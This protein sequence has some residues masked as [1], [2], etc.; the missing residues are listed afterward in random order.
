MISVVRLT[1]ESALHVVTSE[2]RGNKV[3]A[4]RR[5]ETSDSGDMDMNSYQESPFSDFRLI[6][7]LTVHESFPIFSV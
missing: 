2:Y 5:I 1:T 3:A 4:S 7:C 6:V